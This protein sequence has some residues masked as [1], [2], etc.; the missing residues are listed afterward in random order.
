[1]IAAG[2]V[3]AVCTTAIVIQIPPTLQ[4]GR[5]IR[6]RINWLNSCA[7]ALKC[8]GKMKVKREAIWRKQRG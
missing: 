1:M 8:I 2:V 5:L 4:R 6:E 3:L 7:L